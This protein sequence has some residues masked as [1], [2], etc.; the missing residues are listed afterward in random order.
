MNENTIL[1]KTQGLEFDDDINKE[2]V[3]Q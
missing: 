1:R 2:E 3:I